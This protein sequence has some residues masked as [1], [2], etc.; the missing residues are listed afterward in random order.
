VR[1]AETLS[2]VRELSGGLSG[3]RDRRPCRR[4]RA[5]PVW[6]ADWYVPVL[7]AGG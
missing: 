4:F 1:C 3:R 5:R 6:R 7:L 2:V